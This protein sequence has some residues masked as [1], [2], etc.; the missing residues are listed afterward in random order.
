M[1]G[2]RISKIMFTNSNL[3]TAGFRCR[4]NQKH[5]KLEY[6]NCRVCI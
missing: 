4:D 6:D 2:L 5:G 1:S 3:V